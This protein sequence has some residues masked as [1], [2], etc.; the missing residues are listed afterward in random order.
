MD[1]IIRPFEKKDTAAVLDVTV[2]AFNMQSSIDA[3]IEA[4][5]GGADWQEVKRAGIRH[6]IETAPAGCAI[7]ELNDVIVGYVGT[8]V[9]PVANRG[10]ITNLTV[11]PSCQGQGIGR[12]LIEWALAYF[13]ANGLYQAKIETLVTNAVGAH[14]YPAMGFEEVAQQAHYVLKL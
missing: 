9:N 14:L 12:R 3:R 2:K 10:T 8:V 4:A 7:A 5:I 6:E 11:D 13:R 1:Y